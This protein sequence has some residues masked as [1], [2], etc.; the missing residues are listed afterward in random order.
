M[1]PPAKLAAKSKEKS[2][3]GEEEVQN[4]HSTRSTGGN[5]V[6]DLIVLAMARDQFAHGRSWAADGAP[7]QELII[8]P[9]APVKKQGVAGW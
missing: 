3:E 1:K 7:A 5:A 6:F 2:T 9:S 8:L 4:V